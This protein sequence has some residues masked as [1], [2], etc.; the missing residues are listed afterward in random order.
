MKAVI[1]TGQVKNILGWI[2]PLDFSVQQKLAFKMRQE[3]HRA[4]VVKFA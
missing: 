1:M 4:L 2:S 3:R